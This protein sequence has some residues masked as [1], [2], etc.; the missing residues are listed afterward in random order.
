MKRFIYHRRPV[1]Q[2]WKTRGDLS[3]EKKP[4]E[5]SKGNEDTGKYVLN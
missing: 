4:R 3:N 2:D 5:R 1:Y